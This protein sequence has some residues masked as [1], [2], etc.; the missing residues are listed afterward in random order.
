MST[1]VGGRHGGARR[2][3][4]RATPPGVRCGGGARRQ[5]GA[6]TD[7]S[8]PGPYLSLSSRRRPLPRAHAVSPSRVRWQRRPLQERQQEQPADV[9]AADAPTRGPPP[10]RSASRPAARRPL[11]SRAI[12]GRDVGLPTQWKRAASRH[13]GCARRRPVGE[14]ARCWFLFF[15]FFCRRGGRRGANVRDSVDSVAHTRSGGPTAAAGTPNAPR[16]RRWPLKPLPMRASE[17][18]ERRPRL[19]QTAQADRCGPPRS[20]TARPQAAAAPRGWSTPWPS[21]AAAATC[22][23]RGGW[24]GGGRLTRRREAV[25]TTPPRTGRHTPPAGHPVRGWGKPERLEMERPTPSAVGRR[26]GRR[27]P[28]SHR[29]RRVARPPHRPPHRAR[30]RRRPCCNAADAVS[31]DAATTLPADATNAV[32]HE[33][34]TVASHA[35]AAAT[36]AGAAT[37]LTA[38]ATTAAFRTYRRA[39]Q[40]PLPPP[41]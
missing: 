31:A 2:R 36:A 32:R 40:C 4:P 3:G 1:R 19:G 5:R 20:T 27:D 29:P 6:S 38:G 34:A 7:V 16:R 25:C 26:G 11:P 10:C 35:A 28:P 18:G 15:F 14:R 30:S 24:R 37:G 17:G 39:A 9:P 23:T 22:G 12:P 41:V 21:F 8:R 13:G 33:A